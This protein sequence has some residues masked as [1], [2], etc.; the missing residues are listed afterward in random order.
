VWR[1]VSRRQTAKILY[2]PWAR[3]I[4]HALLSLTAH[5]IGTDSQL[6]EAVSQALFSRDGL[7]L[8]IVRWARPGDAGPR[9]AREGRA[10]LQGACRWVHHSLEQAAAAGLRQQCRRGETSCKP[11]RCASNGYAETTTHLASAHETVLAN[12]TRLLPRERPLPRYNIGGSDLNGDD[13]GKFRA[14]GAVPCCYSRDG[15]FDPE[16]DAP[17]T[18]F[19]LRARCAGAAR[20]VMAAN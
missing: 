18:A 1:P 9:P 2:R 3:C 12:R 8:N 14:G 19:L 7:G 11:V 20:A 13:L 5:A 10:G 6:L 4:G 16:P 15:S 17:Q